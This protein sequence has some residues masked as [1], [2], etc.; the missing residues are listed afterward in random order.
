V[1]V[2]ADGFA[3]YATDFDLTS[4]GKQVLIKLQRPRAQVSEYGDDTGRPA[5]VQPGVQEHRPDAGKPYTAPTSV[6]PTAAS[7]TTP[8][9]TTPPANTPATAPGS[10]PAPTSPGNPQ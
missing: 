1:Q 3:T 8:L 6:P 7:P 5:Q 4:A 10:S 2:I 9:K